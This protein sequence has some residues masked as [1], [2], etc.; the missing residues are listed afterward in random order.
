MPE[1]PDGATVYRTTP[2]FDEITVP[3]GLLDSHQTK[4][5]VW[6]RICVHEGTV[7]Y[8]IFGPSTAEFRLDSRYRGVIAPEV[9]HCIE[10]DGPASFHIEF[11]RVEERSGN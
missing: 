2:R 9:P 10:L 11:L 4:A 3:V 1:L 6:G 5:G 7:I 8:R